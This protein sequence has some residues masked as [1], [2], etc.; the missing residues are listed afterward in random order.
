MCGLVKILVLYYPNKIVF[1]GDKTPAQCAEGI[2][3][4]KQGELES[5]EQYSARMEKELFDNYLE[6]FKQLERD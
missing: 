5:Y 6:K 2:L 3:K 1:G 4:T